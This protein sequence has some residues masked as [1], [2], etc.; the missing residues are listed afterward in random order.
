M[1]SRTPAGAHSLSAAEDLDRIAAPSLT[2]EPPVSP[3]IGPGDPS[4]WPRGYPDGGR[5]ACTPPRGRGRPS[6]STRSGSMGRNDLSGRA[7]AIVASAGLAA[8]LLAFS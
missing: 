6:A 5:G 3:G 8:S 1:K 7:R 4:Q 2:V